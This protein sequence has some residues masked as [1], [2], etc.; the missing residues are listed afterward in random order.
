MSILDGIYWENEYKEHARL[1]A[2]IRMNAKLQDE[3][4]GKM[5]CNDC[6]IKDMCKYAFTIEFKNYNKELFDVE[7]TCKNKIK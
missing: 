5:P 2:E 7:I 1:N 6:S 4:N 3:F